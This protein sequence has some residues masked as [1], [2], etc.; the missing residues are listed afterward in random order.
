M[1]H[2]VDREPEYCALESAD[3]P[4]L[5]ALLRRNMPLFS[6]RECRTALAIVA[7]GLAR[8]GDD[9]PYCATIIKREARVLGFAC[10]GTVP[11]TQ[12]CFDLYWIAVD[13]ALHGRGLGRALLAH[14]EGEML[15]L[16][17][18]LLVAETSGRA[19]YVR[20]RRFYTTMGFDE[21]TCIKDFYR[22]GE[23]K[24]IYVKRLDARNLVPA[25]G[26]N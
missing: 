21:I 15:R 11:M 7:E 5:E 2:P 12:G 3:L 1:P 25:P 4:A 10:Y 9:D 13:P 19:D 24:L 16:D 8:P 22:P 17:A 26:S 18:R 6:E 20:A 23:D 14:C